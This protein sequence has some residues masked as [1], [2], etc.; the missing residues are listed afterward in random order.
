MD[1]TQMDCCIHVL[2]GERKDGNIVKFSE[3]SFKKVIDSINVWKILDGREREVALALNAETSSCKDHDVLFTLC[4]ICL[5]LLTQTG[6]GFHRSCYAK[7]TDITRITAA[8]KRIEKRGAGITSVEEIVPCPVTTRESEDT[9]GGNEKPLLRSTLQSKRPRTGMSGSNCPEGCKLLFQKKC[10]ICNVVEKYR[11]ETHSRKRLR[12]HLTQCVTLEAD[13][14][15][16]K[17]A[18]LKHHEEML[19]KIRNQDLVAKEAHYHLSC[20]KDYTRCLNPPN[21][22]TVEKDCS[23]TEAFENFCQAVVE[24]KIIKA[25]EVMRMNTLTRMLHVETEQKKH[26]RDSSE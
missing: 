23:D 13:S 26:M 20:Y 11:V 14:S 18:E 21:P 15:L 7:F 10:L 25:G 2:P 4:D 19:L 17:V 9:I 6:F 8:K 16:K 24:P 22:K 3:K 5:G 1:E 12:E